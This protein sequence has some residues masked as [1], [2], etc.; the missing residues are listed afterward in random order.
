MTQAPSTPTNTASG[1]RTLVTHGLA[2]AVLGC[3]LLLGAC[4]AT[5]EPMPDAAAPDVLRCERDD[6]EGFDSP[7]PL[8]DGSAMG[9]I[10]PKEDEDW[11]ALEVTDAA[12]LVKVSLRMDN[13]R[14]LVEATYA[15][16][17]TDDAGAPVEA[18]ALPDAES[19]GG[20]LDGTHLLP[21]GDYFV[22]VRDQGDDTEDLRNHYLLDVQKLPQPDSQEP[23]DNLDGATAVTAGETQTGYLASTMDEDWYSFDVPAGSV[24]RITL[25][26]PNSDV[27]A[28]V[29][30]VGPD[31]TPIVSDADLADDGNDASL[32]IVRVVATAGTYFVVVE[33]DDGMNADSETAY[34]LH[35]EVLQDLD[36]NEPNDHPDEATPLSGAAINCTADWSPALQATGTVGSPGDNDWYAL[37]LNGCV[38]AVIEADVRL[39]TGL[40]DADGWALQDEVQASVTLVREHVG[41]PCA[42]GDDEQCR[43]LT[44]ACDVDDE[45]RVSWDCESYFNACTGSGL[46][47]GAT[48]CLPTGNCGANQTQRFY[49]R[50]VPPNPI[51]APPTNVA[52]LSAPIRA[53]GTYYLRVSDF[54]ADGGDP[55]ALYDLQARVRLDPDPL[56]QSAT[57]NNPYSNSLT[58]EDVPVRIREELHTTIPVYDATMAGAGRCD[59]DPARW[60]GGRL[61]YENDLDFWRFDSPCPLLEGA[62]DATGDCMLG[63]AYEVDPGATDPAIFVYHDGGGLAA[64]FPVAAGS[65]GY[66]GKV[67]SSDEDACFFAYRTRSAYTVVIR[68]QAEDGRDW[69]S[70]QGYR[71]C[72]EKWSDTCTD[73][74]EDFGDA[75]CGRPQ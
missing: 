28:T 23:N 33:D 56:D 47:A 22:V 50:Q 65:S 17:S 27:D 24:V 66:F 41:S 52:L 11:Y 21:A 75:G 58:E 7:L 35:I 2:I 15:I 73:P 53:D 13:V 14:A 18:V 62:A 36:T 48:V 19:I 68:D 26:M 49:E 30:L 3:G 55:Q 42:A 9:S 74:C 59:A 51:D 60:S 4:K 31:G 1:P 45:V 44:I 16:W 40:S 32:R 69:D 71:F 64:S 38:G 63:L 54:Q 43:E 72:V 46:C 6:S 39:G 20:P 12:P 67:G 37:T 61:S 29:T 10:C 5:D 70:D 8:E 34:E 25:T 57:G